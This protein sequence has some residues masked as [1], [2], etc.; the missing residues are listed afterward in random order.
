MI[1]DKELDKLLSA[2]N[3]HIQG[4]ED[5]MQ[6]LSQKMAAVDMVMQYKEREEKAYRRRSIMCFAAGVGV[7]I[8][9]VLASMFLPSPIEML[10]FSSHFYLLQCL[11][12]NIHYL[13]LILCL[14]LTL[15][16]VMGLLGARNLKREIREAYVL[17]EKSA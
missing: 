6:I 7:G 1:D 4:G 16:G 8:L 2:Y 12:G 14:G 10:H 9:L 11:L 17:Q 3:P 5:F 15:Y 13:A